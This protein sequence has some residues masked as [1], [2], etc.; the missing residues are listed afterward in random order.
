MVNAN[1]MKLLNEHGKKQDWNKQQGQNKTML[2]TK[3]TKAF[4]INGGSALLVVSQFILVIVFIGLLFTT[5]DYKQL[6]IADMLSKLLRTGLVQTGI[7]IF[8]VSVIMLITGFIIKE[9]SPGATLE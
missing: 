7:A 1:T 4:L 9:T 8:S 2:H 3:R 5:P 6:P